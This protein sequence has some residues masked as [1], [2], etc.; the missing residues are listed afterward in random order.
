L[1]RATQI[2]SKV[3]FTKKYVADYVQNYLGEERRRKRIYNI[4]LSMRTFRTRLKEVRKAVEQHNLKVYL[5]WGK[6]DK[7]LPVA[8]AYRF[9]KAVPQAELV[10]LDGGH[11]IVD[12]KLNTVLNK[13]LS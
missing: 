3:G 12:E 1:I 13:L 10:L 5:L 8:Y 2:F 9:K 11:F 6:R 4:W 7:V